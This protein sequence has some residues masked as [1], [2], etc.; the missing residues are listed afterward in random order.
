MSG[1]SGC[2][3]QCDHGGVGGGLGRHGGIRR[4]AARAR[5]QG[6]GYPGEYPNIVTPAA[7]CPVC[8]LQVFM[9]LLWAY[10]LLLTY[11]AWYRILYS[12]GDEGSN[13]WRSGR[14]VTRDT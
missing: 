11:R 7:T 10:S 14:H 2:H 8:P 3:E 1:A 9:F 6:C 12:D 5:H 13:M 4:G